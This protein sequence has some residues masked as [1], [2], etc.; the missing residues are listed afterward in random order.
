MNN[1]K[2]CDLGCGTKIRNPFNASELYGVDIRDGLE[3]SDDFI[4]SADLT[5]EPIPF[6][7]E[8][9]DYV[10][11]FDFI[12]HIP[13]VIYNP[14]RRNPFVELM[15]EVYRV[16][17]VGGIFLS[18]TPAY[19]KYQVFRDPTHVNIITDETFLLYFDNKYR[20]ASMYGFNGKFQIL[21]QSWSDINL[22]TL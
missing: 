14:K 4:K 15:N 22:G 13:R 11:A 19:P 3:G 1:K 8:F 20:W 9:F 18:S 16:L 5:V 7:T 2:S 12:E 6:Q 10:T 17:K 21:K